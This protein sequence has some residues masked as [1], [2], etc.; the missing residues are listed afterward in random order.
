MLRV[1]TIMICVMLNCL[2]GFRGLIADDTAIKHVGGTIS[3]MDEHP[4]IVLLSEHVHARVFRKYALVECVFFLRNEGPETVVEIGFPNYVSE[5]FNQKFEYFESFVNGRKVDI[6][7]VENE[8]HSPSVWYIKE[9]RFMEGEFIAIRDVY[10]GGFGF[11]TGM[12]EWFTYVLKTGSSWSGMI[13]SANIVVTFEDFGTDLLTHIEPPGYELS[14]NEVRWT[15]SRFEPANDIEVMWKVEPETKIESELHRLAA[16]GDIEGVRSLIEFHTNIDSLG[17]YGMTPLRSAIRYGAGPEMV[18]F[19][20]EKGADPNLYL[21]GWETPLH[22]AVRMNYN[23]ISDVVRV[24]L[25]HGADV[26]ARVGFKTGKTTLS[27]AMGNHGPAEVIELLITYGADVNATSS[28]GSTALHWGCL[29]DISRDGLSREE[30]YKLAYEKIT[31]LL[32]HGADPNVI[33]K[34]GKAPIDY[35]KTDDIRELLLSHGAVSGDDKY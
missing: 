18:A 21:K 27:L 33:D 29:C 4:S 24:L 25:E 16:L 10:K 3:P 32:A 12:N 11:D 34:Q 15:F 8:H 19:L 2:C 9:V 35:A 22:V 23:S 14:E 13:E 20:L 17:D 6:Q 28:S 26:D 5:S 31:I 1:F 30:V 7:I